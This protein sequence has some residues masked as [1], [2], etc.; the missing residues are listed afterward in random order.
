MAASGPMETSSPVRMAKCRPSNRQPKLITLRFPRNTFLPEGSGTTSAPATAAQRAPTGRPANTPITKKVKRQPGKKSIVAISQD[1]TR[2]KPEIHGRSACALKRN[3]SFSPASARI[4]RSRQ[5]ATEKYFSA[6]VLRI[7]PS[8]FSST[9]RNSISR[10]ALQGCP[11]F[12]L[13]NQS[14]PEVTAQ[15]ASVVPLVEMTGMP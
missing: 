13:H 12:R 3:R 9:N 8:F 6:A 10:M 2:G 15:S 11:D 7:P 5:A 14:G 1:R 4:N